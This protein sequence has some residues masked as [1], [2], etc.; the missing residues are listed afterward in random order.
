MGCSKQQQIEYLY[1]VAS[2]E[3]NSVSGTREEDEH[4]IYERFKEECGAY[5]TCIIGV[6]KDNGEGNVEGVT[7]WEDD[8]AD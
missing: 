3:T 1:Y 2:D 8:F 5:P 4:D 6:T 7:V